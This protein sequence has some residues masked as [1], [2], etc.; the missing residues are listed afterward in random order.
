M[1]IVE[2]I[3]FFAGLALFLVGLLLLWQARGTRGF[4][5]KK[6]AGVL[7]LAAG[8]IVTAIGLGLFDFESLFG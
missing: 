3:R 6:Q 7:A 4:N 5:Q 1:E 8:V 2:P